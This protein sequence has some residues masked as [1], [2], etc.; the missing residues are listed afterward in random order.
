MLRNSKMII[1]DKAKIASLLSEMAARLAELPLED[2]ILVG[3]QRRGVYLSRRL[4]DLIEASTGRKVSLG[5]LDITFYRDDLSMIDL[6]PVVRSTDLPDDINGKI[7]VLVDDVLF[8]GRTIRAALDAL[9]DNGRARMVKLAVLVDRGWRE[10]PIQADL[11]G[12]GVKTE[13]EEKINVKV[14]E[15][16]GE[17][18]VEVVKK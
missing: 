8:T 2:V 11:V 6:R 12:L 5:I 15:L 14:Q 4:A 16:D 9:A 7:V 10:L 1:A 17:D 13:Y 3:I 18:L